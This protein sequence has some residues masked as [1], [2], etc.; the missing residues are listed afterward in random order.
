[1]GVR[2]GGEGGDKETR[3]FKRLKTE[4]NRPRYFKKI[5]HMFIKIII[6]RN[7]ELMSLKGERTSGEWLRAMMSL[8]GERKMRWKLKPTSSSF[9]RNLRLQRGTGKE[10]KRMKREWGLM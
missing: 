2:R 6:F 1:M 3:A 10:R 8:K 5:H 7:S 4:L 9:D